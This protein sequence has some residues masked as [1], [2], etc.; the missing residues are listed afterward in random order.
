MILNDIVTLITG[1]ASLNT[2]ITGGIKHNHVDIDCDKTKNWVTFTWKKTSS[3]DESGMKDAVCHYDLI[4]QCISPVDST[5]IYMGE[6]LNNY[7]SNYDDGIKIRNVSLKG[8]GEEIDWD[9]EK[10]VWFKTNVYDILYV[11]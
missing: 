5:T 10:K 8:D 3:E 1:N 9:S 7:L 6:A 4:I 2:F 11:K